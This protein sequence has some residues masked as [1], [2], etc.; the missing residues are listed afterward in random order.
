MPSPAE[1][2][3]PVPSPDDGSDAGPRN[4][5]LRIVSA[6]VLAPVALVCVW[7]GDLWFSSFIAIVVLAASGEWRTMAGLKHRGVGTLLIMAPFFVLIAAQAAGVIPAMF[8]LLIG[9]GLAVASF[10][11]SWH[12]RSWVFVGMA[13]L[14]VATL[15]LFFLRT[16]PD[17]GRDLVIFVFALVWLSDT[18]GYA[19][20]RT[21]GGPKLAPRISPNKTWS[22]AAGA[23]VLTSA[24]AAI[25]ANFTALEIETVLPIAVLISIATQ[26]GDIFESWVKRYFDV[27]D[28]GNLIPGHGGV[29]D[30]IDGVLFAAP[31]LALYVLLNGLEFIQWR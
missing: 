29:L 16:Q 28:S 21:F 9:L 4:L 3:S 31:V 11:S 2:T 12:E 23:L 20:G 25:F 17:I 26:L 10:G 27:K 6:L 22:G 7:Q 5:V 24:G 1:P 15:A 19:A 30:R 13:H 18:G 14:G 8:A